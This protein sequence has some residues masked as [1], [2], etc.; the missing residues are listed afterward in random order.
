LDYKAIPYTEVL[1]T[2]EVYRNVIVP[3]VG[4]RFIPVLIS[5]DDVA[6][7]DS[8]EIIDFLE[9][10]YPEPSIY[11]QGPVQRF[12][13]LLLEAYADEWLVIPAMHYRWNVPENRAFAIAEF[14]KL[15]A[16][17]ASAAEQL[18]IGE[19]LSGPFAGA[20]GPLGVRSENI[21]EIESSYLAFLS[22]FERHLATCSFLFGSRPSIADFALY[23]PL[24]AHLYRDPASG[25]LMREH[26]PA[27]GRWVE[28]MRAPLPRSGELLADDVVPT[29]LAPIIARM[30]REFVPVLAST[31]RAL[32]DFAAAP[33]AHDRPLPRAIGS[34]TF[35]LG[36]VTGERAIYPF[37]LWRWQRAADQ[38]QTLPPA[39]RARADEL[40]QSEWCTQPAAPRLTRRHNRLH[41][42]SAG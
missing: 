40:L 29:T 11:P 39:A 18:R 3:R 25:R 13:A 21:G 32:T 27:V 28:R 12:F 5:D 34:H 6:V 23:G 7:Q 33:E 15:S 42:A 38:Y 36:E 17:D 2:R 4:V 22:D 19:Q 30:V 8:T 10:R 14:G 20:L 1:A 31:Q 35:R 24:Y 26:A 41:L 16:P 9:A 37:N